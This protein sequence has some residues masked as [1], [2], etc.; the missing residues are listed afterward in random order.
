MSL[1]VSS[2]T[3]AAPLAH[4]LSRVGAEALL[5]SLA[6]LDPGVAVFAVDAD[7]NLALWSRGAERLLGYTAGEVLGAYC[8]K[9]NRCQS[10]MT[11]CGIALHGEVHD[12]PLTLMHADGT[13]V[14]VRKH[15]RAFLG[16]KGEFLGG[17]EVLVPDSG[18]P[19]PAG[20][21]PSPEVVPDLV[22]FH[23]LLTREPS[24]LQAL[25]V[26][27]N[28]ARTDTTVLVRGE[29]G[30]G[31]E[32]VA[33]AIHEESHRRRGP[34]LALNCAALS[35]M[36]L[37]SELF[38]HKRGAFTG[39]VHDHKGLF[40]QAAG[41]TLFLDEVAE[42]PLDLQAKLLRV[43]QDHRITPVGGTR[44]MKVDVRI[45]AATHRSLRARV[46]EGRFR[47]DLMYRI[48]VVPLYLP[49]LR[50]RRR[51]IEALL[52]RFLEARSDPKGR[53]IR[54]VEPEAM[55]AL[56]DYPWP[57]NVRELQNVVE[58]A[59]AVGRGPVLRLAQLPP[60]FRQTSPPGGPGGPTPLAPPAT[61]PWRRLTPEAARA[62]LERALAD[63]GGHVGRAAASLGIS[64]PTFWRRRRAL[65]LA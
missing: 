63:A 19:A 33:R 40:A 27:R 62:R 51:D 37:E 45:L 47:E 23:G 32:L 43:L 28:V 64:R 46:A 55:R 54:Q 6:E 22:E 35:P 25:E 12:V 29:S 36:L 61:V 56:L 14:P 38:G 11:G 52:R 7:R 53:S 1:F 59:F 8:L 21:P 3:A 24:V 17:V 41:G 42:L 57:G 30:T 13:P 16:P 5:S 20:A 10:C 18:Q 26:V 44:S 15:A 50:E 4:L 9:A 48:R 65:G 2:R 58:Y 60:E 31:K 49:P 34:F 39:A